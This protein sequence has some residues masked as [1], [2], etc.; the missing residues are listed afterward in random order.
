MLSGIG[1]RGKP[2][3]RGAGGGLCAG[4]ETVLL[5]DASSRVELGGATHLPFLGVLIGQS[6][7]VSSTPG[8]KVAPE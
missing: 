6:S 4:G 8:G 5:P 7:D 1:Q 2:L 3:F